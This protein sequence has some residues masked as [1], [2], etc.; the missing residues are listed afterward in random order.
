MNQRIS[1]I[2][3]RIFEPINYSKKSEQAREKISAA[4]Q[5]IYDENYSDAGETRTEGMI[6]QNYGSCEKYPLPQ[7]DRERFS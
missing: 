6:M 5:E 1:D 2:V 3:D 7:H 4:F